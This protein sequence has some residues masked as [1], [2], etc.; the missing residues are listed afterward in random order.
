MRDYTEV[1][2]MVERVVHKYTHREKKKKLYSGD[3]PLTQT[4]L[5]TLASIGAAP[6]ISVTDL[7][8]QKGVT[9][10][11]ISQMLG[12][13]VEKNLVQKKAS[14]KSDAMVEL[15]LTEN[16]KECYQEYTRQR[17]EEEKQWSCLLDLLDEETYQSLKKVLEGMDEL[18]G[19]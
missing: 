11:A 15:Y 12:R 13:L 4:E 3:L 8:R 5:R 7:A 2:S 17:K 6:G 10:G 9:L 18:L 1:F 14:P 19:I 16:G